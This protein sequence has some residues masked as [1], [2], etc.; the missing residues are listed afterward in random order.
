MNKKLISLFL[1][2]AV[3]TACSDSTSSGNAGRLAPLVD[4]TGNQTFDAAPNEYIVVLKKGADAQAEA[5]AA[6]AA[7]GYVMNVWK[8]SLNG[9]AIRANAGTLAAIRRSNL[10]DFVQP[11][12][13]MTIDVAQP[14]APYTTC[15]W[16][17]DRI[18]ETGAP[19]DGI[20]NQPPVRNPAGV[21][22]KAILP[23][24]GM[25]G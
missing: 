9:Y 21:I 15:S 5:S 10:V 13:I 8:A 4:A 23:S 12:L 16:G 11:N 17:L 25:T 19:L 6:R 7:G 14:C 18:D 22:A 2:G 24:L 20:Y 1:L 3:V